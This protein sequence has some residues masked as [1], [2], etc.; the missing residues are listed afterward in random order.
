VNVFL[1][2]TVAVFLLIILVLP[3]GCSS[4]LTTE[5]PLNKAVII[6]QLSLRDPNPEFI[7][8]VKGILE[9]YGFTVDVRQGYDITVDFYRQLPSMGY[10][11]VLLRVHSGT[12][13][14]EEGE[15]TSISD[16][17]YLFTNE[18][19]STT[20]YIGDQLSDRVS[21]ALMEEDTPLVFAVNSDFMKNA[22]GRF[23]GS[24][25]LSMGCESFK[26]TDMPAAFLEKGAAAYIGWS[27]IVTLDHVDKATL[28]LI[29]NLFTA[30]MTL[31]NGIM[32]TLD[33]F[34]YDPYYGSYLKCAPSSSANS[35]VEDI[36][37][38][39]KK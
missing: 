33:R 37:G 5:P 15:N 9:D 22:D 11:F 2:I 31:Y 39:L 24:F 1:K 28:D 34:G 10:R 18:E 35:T 7:T 16:T 26:Y 13:V 27:D 3:A 23:N 20:K 38:K 19:Y 4:P 29:Q 17:T 32:T 36:L 8:T 12:L 6:D 14:T 30:D 21:N 25:I